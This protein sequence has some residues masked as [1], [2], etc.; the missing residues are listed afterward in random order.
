MYFVFIL[1]LYGVCTRIQIRKRT[2]Y[3]TEQPMYTGILIQSV[4]ILLIHL[5]LISFILV[6][7][8]YIYK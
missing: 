2:T 5:E 8:K 4:D 3:R 7:K 6:L 1:L